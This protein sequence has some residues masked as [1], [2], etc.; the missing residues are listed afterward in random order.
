MAHSSA[1]VVAS[2]P[3]PVLLTRAVEPNGITHGLTV[4]VGELCTTETP[5]CVALV[6]STPKPSSEDLAHVVEA[7]RTLQGHSSAAVVMSSPEPVPSTRAVEHEAITKGLK[8][9]AV[10]E[11]CTTETPNCVALVASTPKPSSEDLAHVVEAVRTL[12]GH[13]SAAVVM[14]SPEPVPSTRAVEHEAITKGLKVVA[15]GELC[16]TETPNCVALV[17]STPKPSSEDLVHVVEAVRT[18]QRHSSAAVVASTPVAMTVRAVV[19]ACTTDEAKD[20]VE[21]EVYTHSR[22]RSVVPRVL[23]RRGLRAIVTKDSKSLL[24]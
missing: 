24:T 19:P 12:Q 16:T 3:K 2:S 20:A 9:V 14:S 8:V 11:L 15:V 10:G 5:N 22:V 23:S 4:V 1:A 13:S 21:G 17:A 18:L 7:V 6:A